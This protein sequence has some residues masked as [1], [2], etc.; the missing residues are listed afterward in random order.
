MALPNAVAAAAREQTIPVE[1]PAA[2]RTI[3]RGDIRLIKPPYE[4]AGERRLG[5]VLS[6]DTTLQFIEI[7]LV[8][9]Y[10]ELA[11][12]TDGIVPGALAGTPYD[13]VVQT[14]LRGVVWTAVQVSQLAGQLDGETLE[15]ISDLVES[16]R[17]E[18]TT[19]IR[20]GTP[21]G[22][23]AD[24]RWPFKAAEGQALDLLT[25]DCSGELLD[26]RSPWRL[27]PGLV[28]PELLARSTDLNSVLI[29]LAHWL[30][31]R[32]LRIMVEDAMELEEHGALDFDAWR[33]AELNPDLYEALI[34]LV[35]H[36]LTGSTA[37]GV[38]TTTTK[39]VVAP[40]S[41]RHDNEARAVVLGT[42][43]RSSS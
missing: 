7:A 12:A 10:R 31:T 2:R 37:P 14:D 18:S 22:G 4:L 16:G 9:P 15:T 20:I 35:E 19:G 30:E 40:Y 1:E 8:H 25:S 13:L 36:A 21:L 6:V 39:M 3:R 27:D 17:P 23:P 34:D 32:D 38:V 29:E 42:L 26:G 28:I 24:R 11:T 5:L 41:Q 33:S 43:A